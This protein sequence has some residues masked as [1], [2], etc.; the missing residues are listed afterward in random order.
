MNEKNTNSVYSV[1]P[2]FSKD[3]VFTDLL[4]YE[5]VHVEKIISY[6]QVTDTD[7]PYVQDHDEWVLVLKG[8]AKLNLEAKEHILEEG[9]YLFIPKGSKHW[10][11][12]TAIPTI[13]L[14]IHLRG[15]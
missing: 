9:R 4:K 8:K 1:F 14:A 3:E 2:K 10:L 12:Y 7:K 15:K 6:G 11:T 5:N 13:W